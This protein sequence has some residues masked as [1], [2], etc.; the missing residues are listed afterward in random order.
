MKKEPRKTY[1]TTTLPY[2][3]S[4]P[5]M[6]HA[7][8]F[9]LAD[10]I[11]RRKRKYKKVGLQEQV[12]FN[13]GL[14]QHGS[15]IADAANGDN[16]FGQPAMP[17]PVYLAKLTELWKEFCSGFDIS[18]DN[19]YETSSSAHHQH[20]KE[21]FEFLREIGDI[22]EKDYE[23]TYCTGCEAY[24]RAS[25]LVEGRCPD[26]PTLH[27]D[28]LKERNW[29]FKLTKYKAPAWYKKEGWLVP[30]TKMGEFYHL[31]NTAEDI[32]VTRPKSRAKW[33]VAVPEC[34]DQ[35]VY[36]WFDA[37]LNY[38]FAPL[39]HGQDWNEYDERIQIC[40]PDNLRFQGIIWQTMLKSLD[41]EHTD[42]LLVHGTILDQAGRK[43]SKTIKNVID[44][45]EQLQKYGKDAVR[46]YLA[47][48]LSTW[49]DSCYSEEQLIHVCNS[50][51]GDNYG[52]LV[53]RVAALLKR[54][55]LKPRL[56]G[57]LWYPSSYAYHDEL[58]NAFSLLDQYKFNEAVIAV[59]AILKDA[60]RY[61]NEA[62][63]WSAK[64]PIQKNVELTEEV[65]N[66]N[67]KRENA[68]AVVLELAEL[69]SAV[70]DFYSCFVP[71]VAKR[72]M[73]LLRNGEGPVPFPKIV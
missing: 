24:K 48:G 17:I 37:L 31:L 27:L 4:T 47:A 59:N 38:M 11:A 9:V 3:N 22:Y 35:L 15:K 61:I 69:L 63:P 72:A 55:E 36:V 70:S 14:D 53:S 33:G 6:G 29:F 5:H 12:F 54:F 40:G 8:E 20:V 16:F 50:D 42:K 66:E 64:N 28:M 52:N 58:D 10:V 7:F 39:T 56:A 46:Y 41:M 67:R 65:F 71:D 18:Y 21:Q 1:I 25:D 68:E 23:G 57:S 30:A 60:N 32:P 73:D 43:M 26:H 2:A 34:E 45:M 19:F 44:P 62:K 49:S 13:I 51:L